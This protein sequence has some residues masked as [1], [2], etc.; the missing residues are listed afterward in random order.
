MNQIGLLYVAISLSR[1]T[2]S[3]RGELALPLRYRATNV[4]AINYLDISAIVNIVGGSDRPTLSILN[5]F[6]SYPHS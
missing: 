5:I 6:T 1:R 2:L 4:F 3:I